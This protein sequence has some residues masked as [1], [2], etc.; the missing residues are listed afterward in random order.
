MYSITGIATKI[1]GTAVKYVSVIAGSSVF[2][3]SDTPHNYIGAGVCGLFYLGGELLQKT[4]KDKELK[5]LE[6]KINGVKK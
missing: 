3:T 1:T 5:N 6:D 4:A 2:I